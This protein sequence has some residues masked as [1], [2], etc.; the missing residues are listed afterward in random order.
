MRTKIGSGWLCLVLTAALL[1]GGNS[2]AAT[3]KTAREPQATPLEFK[4][5]ER[6]KN[7]K[8]AYVTGTSAADGTRYVASNLIVTQPIIVTLKADN[9]K[10]KI[11]LLV[12]KSEW[13][14]A[15][16]EASTGADGRVQVK[17]RTQGDFG[18]VVSGSGKPYRM[19]VWV[20]DEVKRPMPPAIVPKAAWKPVAAGKDSPK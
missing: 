20:G 4:K 16:R 3:K 19:A 8:F 14:K 5:I 18:L 12:T 7:G 13:N 2:A 17:F 6:V 9:P 1:A 11:R 10:D 15:D